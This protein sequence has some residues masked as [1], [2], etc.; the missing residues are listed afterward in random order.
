M[1]TL[2]HTTADLAPGRSF[3]TACPGGMASQRQHFPLAY[4]VA[5]DAGTRDS[6]TYSGYDL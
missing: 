3:P 4:L 5:C 2:D 6:R 1:T